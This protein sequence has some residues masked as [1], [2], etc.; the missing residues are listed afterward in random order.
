VTAED[1]ARLID[2]VANGQIEPT[3]EPATRGG[4]GRPMPR[5]RVSR[6]KS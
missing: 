2:R 4:Q 6:A 3:A 5:R 1:F